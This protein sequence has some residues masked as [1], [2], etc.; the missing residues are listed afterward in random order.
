MTLWC[1][2]I[3][4]TPFISIVFTSCFVLSNFRFISAV[5]HAFRTLCSLFLEEPTSGGC[6]SVVVRDHYYLIKIR[7]HTH[8]QHSHVIRSARSISLGMIDDGKSK[9]SFLLSDFFSI[10]GKP[11][12][13]G[14]D[15]ACP[16]T[17]DRRDWMWCIWAIVILEGYR[18]CVSDTQAHDWRCDNVFGDESG[19]AWWCE[20]SR[21]W[22][23]CEC[24]VFSMVF[25]AINI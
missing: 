4:D 13:C 12:R 19:Q 21:W 23:E 24:L 17:N 15:S 7:G 22:P 10:F 5:F 1:I 9:L 6:F 8:T 16:L 11:F 20:K 3:R 14:A 25:T 18:I 2:H